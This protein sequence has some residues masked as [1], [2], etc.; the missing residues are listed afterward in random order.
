[1]ARRGNEPIR[2][3]LTKL[4]PMTTDPVI[5]PLRIREELKNIRETLREKKFHDNS[6]SVLV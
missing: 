2:A 3:R 4:D 1:M 5:K 6:L